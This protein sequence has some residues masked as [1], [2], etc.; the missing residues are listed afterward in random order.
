MHP[1]NKLLISVTRE[2]SNK[3]KSNEVIFKQLKNI[4]FILINWA[5]LKLFSYID[6]NDSQL[7]N[8]N[9]VFIFR[10]DNEQFFMVISFNFLQLKNV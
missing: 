5:P 1:A 8:I 4:E 9:L 3:S 10:P 6:D 2:V 7:A